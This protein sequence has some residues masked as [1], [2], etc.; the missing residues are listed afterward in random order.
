MID[1]NQLGITQEEGNEII[2]GR[3]DGAMLMPNGKGQLTTLKRGDAVVDADGTNNLLSFAN[4]PDGYL[5]RMI[6]KVKMDNFSNRGEIVNGQTIN[7]YDVDMTLNHVVDF[8]DII[9]KM[10]YSSEFERLVQAIAV[11]PMVGK[12]KLRKYLI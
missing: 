5:Q 6:N 7:E 12:S 2:L 11:D 9:Q 8:K 10:K 3:S 4:N 1:R